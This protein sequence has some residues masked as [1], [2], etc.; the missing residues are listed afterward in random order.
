GT[1]RHESRRVDRQLRGR[2]GRQGDPGS[3]QFFVSLEDNLMRIFG[4]DRI[5]KLMDR[6]GLEEGEVIQHSM[7]TKSIERA[8]KK[9]EEN[10][11]AIRKRLLE[12]DDVMN[13]QR[14][15]IYERRRNALF[16]E[17]LQLDIMNMI[18]DTC[19]DLV[20]NTKAT[21]DYDGFKL[22]AISVLGTDY[23]INK[24]GF[25]AVDPSVLTED[26]Y[27]QAYKHY[28]DKNALIAQRAFPIFKDIQKNRGA[29]I[30]DV[31]VPFTDKI[32]QI[33]V[34][35][36]LEKNI[37]TECQE[38]VL[39]MEKMLTLAFIDQAWKEHLRE[40]DDLKQSV[41]NAVYE[42]KDPLLIYKFESFELFKRFI[43]KVNEDTVSFL[44]KADLPVK[45][46]EEVQE[47][48]TRRS[49]QKYQ[50]SK[51]ESQSLLS[52]KGED[53]N[54]PPVEKAAP[55]KSAKVA[56]RNERVTVQYINGNI[57]K[58]VKFKTVEEDIRN[59]KCVLIDQA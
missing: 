43:A 45:Q 44:M 2:S 52:G 20:L 21:S 31:A 23:E 36:N 59:N 26:L 12:Y 6:M 51:A 9:V 46:S 37:N 28:H 34:V 41:Q 47:A 13:S 5:A 39:S 48:H 7:I 3:S 11:F 14:E 17:R 25:E 42:Q 29:T 27:N 33:S 24:E 58:D 32:K 57:K 35:T 56:G 18:Y 19:E 38:L 8:Q 55:V 53:K 40:M 15:V 49:Q 16:G 22:T 50:E 30:E 54:R 10:N 1:E 4:S